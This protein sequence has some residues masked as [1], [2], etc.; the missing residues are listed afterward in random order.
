[1]PIASALRRFQSARSFAGTPS[2]PYISTS[3]VSRPG[4]AFSILAKVIEICRVNIL[5]QIEIDGRS[6]S[7]NLPVCRQFMH[8]IDVNRQTTGR[9]QS[10][11]TVGTSE[12]FRLL[13]L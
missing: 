6:N 9:I 11:R 5:S 1:M 2:I 8:L 12:M 4:I 7:S 13:M 10:T 3:N